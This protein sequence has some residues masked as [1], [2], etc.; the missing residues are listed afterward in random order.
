MGVG[1]RSLTWNSAVTVQGGVSMPRSC[2]IAH[3]AVQLL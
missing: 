3:A 2:I 1:A